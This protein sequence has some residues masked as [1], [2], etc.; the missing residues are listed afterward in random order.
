MTA[1]IQQNVVPRHRSTVSATR[2]SRP[3]LQR[4]RFSLTS[5]RGS[6]DHATLT[7]TFGVVA[8]VVVGLLGFF[9]LQQVMNTASEGTDMHELETQIVE[10]RE[11][12]KELELEGAQLRSLQA[13][14]GRIDQLN[15]VETDKVSYLVPTQSDTA[16]ALAEGI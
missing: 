4:S 13:V 16:V 2:T 5:Q 1:N 9:Y 12:Q 10:L 8:L 6:V 7:I 15:L 3:Q 14:E 11:Q